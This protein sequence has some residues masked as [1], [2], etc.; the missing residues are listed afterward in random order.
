MPGAIIAFDQD[1]GTVSSGSP[2]VARNDGRLSRLV[3]AR[4]TV[5]GNSTYEW[6]L[7]DKPPGSAVTLTGEDTANCTFTPDLPGTYR[8]QLVTNGGGPGNVQIL[9]FAVRYDTNG[10]LIRRG[11][12]MP[13]FGESSSENNFGG[14]TR[15]W[16]EAW[17]YVMGDIRAAL[18]SLS[19]KPTVKAVATTNTALTGL[20]T[21]D[22]YALS[23]GDRVLL[24]GQSAPAENGIWA[25]S[26]GAW[27]RADDLPELSHASGAHVF[28]ER[29][30][31]YADSL[32]RCTTNGP[33]DVVG[34]DGLVWAQF[35]GA[36]S[37]D[38]TAG[39]KGILQLAGDLGGTAASPSVV[40]ASGAAGVFSIT[41][42]TI[43]STANAKLQLDDVAA[44]DATPD[45]TPKVIYTWSMADARYYALRAIVT[46]VDST[47]ATCAEFAIEAGYNVTGGAPAERHKTITE[48]GAASGCALSLNIVGLSVTLTATGLGTALTWQVH[49]LTHLA[50]P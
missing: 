11:W 28:V 15:G 12:R 38:A 22:G 35:T 13:A 1:W 43:R 14:Q 26:A 16:A 5:S 48:K 9:V 2:G 21:I 7:L 8:M 40:S 45:A 44:D 32:W 42:A 23:E 36:A 37:P 20:T 30:T 6:S 29:G 49:D 47:G 31:V 17:E 27:S 10:I 25:S 3:T 4:S 18:E 41:A 46:A 19:A 24:A 33:T 34:T 39:T 50:I